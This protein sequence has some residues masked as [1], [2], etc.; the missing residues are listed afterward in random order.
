MPWPRGGLAGTPQGVFRKPHF[1]KLHFRKPHRGKPHR[2][3]PETPLRKLVELRWPRGTGFTDRRRTKPREGSNAQKAGVRISCVVL[4]LH[5]RFARGGS[6]VHLVLPCLLR[7]VQG[8]RTT[9]GGMTR[10]YTLPRSKGP[11]KQHVRYRRRKKTLYVRCSAQCRIL[12]SRLRHK[13]PVH[14]AY[15]TGFPA[16]GGSYSK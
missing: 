12:L 4:N 3:S 13:R 11:G 8:S 16:A 1:R 14:R 9:I 10:D 15:E 7:F 2:V 6:G 5:R